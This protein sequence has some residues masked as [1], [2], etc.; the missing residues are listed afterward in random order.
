MIFFLKT[1]VFTTFLSF[2]EGFQEEL[3]KIE[4]IQ[5]VEVPLCCAG[6]HCVETPSRSKSVRRSQSESVHDGAA[7]EVL[8]K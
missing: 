5:L 7:V 3:A 6:V 4:D 8:E 2:K 1:L